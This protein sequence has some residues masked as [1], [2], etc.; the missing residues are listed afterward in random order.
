MGFIYSHLLTPCLQCLL[1]V[2]PAPLL[3]AGPGSLGSDLNILPQHLGGEEFNSE[4]SLE[5]LGISDIS[6]YPDVYKIALT[7]THAQIISGI[8]THFP[9]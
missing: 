4:I 5:K 3:L 6:K 1:D 8:V 7:L 2:M 9:I